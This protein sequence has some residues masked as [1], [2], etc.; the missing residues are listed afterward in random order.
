MRKLIA[1]AVVLLASA[2]SFACTNLIVGR[3]ASQDGSVFCT[4]SADDYGAYYALAHFPAARHA[5]GEMRA[6]IDRDTNEPH[7]FIPEAAET[8]NVVGYINEH[9]VT[10]GET[11][12]GGREEMVDTTG[13]LDYGSLMYIALQR[14][15][16]AREAI[17]VM[18]TL[19]ERYGYNS[20]GETF[21]VCDPNE[22]WIMEMMGARDTDKAK[23]MKVVWVALRI[24]DDAICAHANQ[25]RISTFDMKD[26]ENVRYSKNVVK[27]ARANGWY[28]GKDADFSFC[29][30]YAAPDFSGRRICEA[31]VWS[32]FNHFADGMGRYVP[33][34]EGKASGTERLP[35]WV[36]PSRKLTLQDVQNSMRDH[37]EGT[38]FALDSDIGGGIWEMPYRLTPLTFKADGKEYFNERPISTQQASMVYVSQMRSWL[39][40]AFG[41]I[42]WYANDDANMCAFTPL[43]CSITRAPQPYHAAG[44][45]DVTFSDKSAFW[46][47]N[48]V[49]NMVYPRY[50]MLF[51]SLKEKRDSLDDSY[52]AAGRAVEADVKRLLD[53]GETA[54]AADCLTAY[55]CQ[56]ADEMLSTWKR[57]AVYLIVKYNDMVVKPE[58]DGQFLRTKYGNG[59]K[60]VRPGYSD[61]YKRELI[62]QTGEKFRMPKE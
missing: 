26:K 27:Y 17:T 12:F 46:I 13:I 37:F 1:L 41:G 20:E 8:Y 52:A 29:D 35:L 62:H 24:P 5:K 43:Y 23:G 39:P 2:T 60:V 6:V 49:S 28:S 15:K 25:S 7:G 38:P 55:S 61:A 34:V 33:Y 32:F 18:T 59:A 48:W 31:R 44:A 51:P 4:Y 54:K 58:K 21:S 56:K 3:G 53:A 16:T 22:A 11:T 9:Q 36:R 42:L 40:N 45:D 19:A 14:S 47:C 50:S 57:L 10:I 30:A